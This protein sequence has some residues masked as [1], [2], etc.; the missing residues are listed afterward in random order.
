[1]VAEDALELRGPLGIQLQPE[2]LVL[3]RKARIGERQVMNRAGLP[4]HQK[5]NEACRRRDQTPVR[6]IKMDSEL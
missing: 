3:G 2:L 5:A 4:C 1:M 6:Q